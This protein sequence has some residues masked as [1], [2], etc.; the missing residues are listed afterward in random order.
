MFN[1]STL[2]FY[3]ILVLEIIL[4]PFL[5]FK[6]LILNAISTDSEVKVKRIR[7]E[8]ET[9]KVFIN[10]HEWGGYDMVREKK[11][12]QIKPFSCG[13]K[14][15]IERFT[16]PSDKYKAEVSVT[17][18]EPQLC[19]NLDLIALQVDHLDFVS[20]EGMDFSG[21]SYFY[22][23]IKNKPNAYVILTNSS[24]NSLQERFLDGYL[25]YMEGNRDVGILGISYCAKVYQ[26]FIRNMFKPH[27]QT[28]FLL[29]TIDVLKEIVEY[30][31]GFPGVGIIDKQ[32]LIRK[33][34]IKISEIVSDLGYNLAVILEN[35][36]PYKFGKHSKWDNAFNSWK[37]QWED[38]RLFVKFPNKI[39]AVKANF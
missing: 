25:D 16:N 36:K 26:T 12:R 37:L 1:Y 18:S 4:F 34:E 27:L 9:M 3:S 5:Y 24:V 22:E 28:F 8:I 6:N 2:K 10:I 29:T 14:Y 20:N 30:N 13:L 17:M 38:V 7:K 35:G 31:K 21:Y 23:K 32:L 33:G 15:Q 39:N 11:V 19:K